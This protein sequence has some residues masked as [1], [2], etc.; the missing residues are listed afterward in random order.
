ML[1]TSDR[2][3]L[4]VRLTSMIYTDVATLVDTQSTKSLNPRSLV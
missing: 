4:N 2:L 1:G 3:S